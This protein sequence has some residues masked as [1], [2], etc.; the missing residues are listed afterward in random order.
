MPY[1][2]QDRY[3]RKLVDMEFSSIVMENDHIKAEFIPALGGR[4]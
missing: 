3:S 1:T 2:M 4:L